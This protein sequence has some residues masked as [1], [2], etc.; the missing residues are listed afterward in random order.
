MC[1]CVC[2]CVCA[3]LVSVWLC[4]MR[5]VPW[6]NSLQEDAEHRLFKNPIGGGF[7]HIFCLSHAKHK[8]K[9]DSG[10]PQVYR[11]MTFYGTMHTYDIWIY[12]YIWVKIL[13]THIKAILT[14]GKDYTGDTGW[15]WVAK[16]FVRRCKGEKNFQEHWWSWCSSPL[17]ALCTS[18]T[19]LGRDPGVAAVP[20]RA[21]RSVCWQ[22]PVGRDGPWR[23]WVGNAV[24]LML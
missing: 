2:V 13:P 7:A 12:I 14:G 4:C 5:M 6:P 15:I 9:L 22:G 23:W 10:P 8:L 24:W 21:C 17:P 18:Y 11:N 1:L 19:W 3:R 20:T 16:R